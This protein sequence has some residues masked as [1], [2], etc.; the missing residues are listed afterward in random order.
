M[1]SPFET[2]VLV[3]DIGVGEVGGG[4][5]SGQELSAG[6][7]VVYQVGQLEYWFESLSDKHRGPIPQ[8][9]EINELSPPSFICARII[10]PRNG[11]GCIPWIWVTETR[12]G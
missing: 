1:K 9:L 4:V 12:R 5:L 3:G 7:T 11:R 2:A 6:I 10:C 8:S